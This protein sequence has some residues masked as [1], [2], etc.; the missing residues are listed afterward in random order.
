MICPHCKKDSIRFLSVWLK[1]PFSKYRCSGC[2]ALSRLKIR[3]RLLCGVSGLFGASAIGL[4]F[5]F[6]SWLVFSIAIAVLLPLDMLMDF[7]LY[8]L[9]AV[10]PKC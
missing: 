7:W 4:G 3:A 10:D 5:Y 8:R 1:G 9:E 2:G 6:H